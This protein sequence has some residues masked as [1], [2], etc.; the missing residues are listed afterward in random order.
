MRLKAR[1]KIRPRMRDGGNFILRKDNV[2][3]K[4]PFI[5]YNDDFDLFTNYAVI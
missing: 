1:G 2:Y 3:V 4:M 5:I